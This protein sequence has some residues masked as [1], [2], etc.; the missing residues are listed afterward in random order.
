MVNYDAD[1]PD[2][3]I[4]RRRKEKKSAVRIDLFAEKDK[5]KENPTDQTMTPFQ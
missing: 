4:N 5:E 3:E 1:T 2:L